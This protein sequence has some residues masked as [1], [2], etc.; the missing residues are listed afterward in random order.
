MEFNL[1]MKN[2]LEYK[3]EEGTAIYSVGDSVV[4]E[5]GGKRCIGKIISIGYYQN[6]DEEA[7]PAIYIDTSKTKTSYSGEV[8]MAEDITYL[9]NASAAYREEAAQNLI[10]IIL[11]YMDSMKEG[12]QDKVG[13]I[14]MG[15]YQL[16]K[17]E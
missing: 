2:H 17:Q 14:L 7:K 9:Y 11:D 15:F 12:D 3:H 8:V 1:E 5:A 6:D 16:S 10:D 13:K 4:C